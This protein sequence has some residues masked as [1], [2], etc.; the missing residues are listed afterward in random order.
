MVMFIP[1]SKPLFVIVSLQISNNYN[2]AELW[3]GEEIKFK[4]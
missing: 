2:Y 4:L 1:N 3:Y